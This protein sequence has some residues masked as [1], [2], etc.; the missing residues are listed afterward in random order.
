MAFKWRLADVQ[1]CPN[2]ECWLDNFVI[3]QVIWTSIAKKIYN[4]VIFQG[5]SDRMPPISE[6]A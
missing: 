4:L 3:F 5:R 6:S 1:W 2:I